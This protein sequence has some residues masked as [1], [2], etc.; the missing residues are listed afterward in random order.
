MNKNHII[1]I[2]AI[3]FIAIAGGLTY[4]LFFNEY[5]ETVNFDGTTLNVPH[6][7]FDKIDQYNDSNGAHVI[8]NRDKYIIKYFY[9]GD[10]NII[11]AVNFGKE[12][13]ELVGQTNNTGPNPVKTT[14]HG[15]T[16]Y[17]CFTSEIEHGN[18]LIISKNPETAKKIYDS[19]KSNPKNN[20]NNPSNNHTNYNIN[21]QS[22]N[23]QNNTKTQQVPSSANRGDSGSTP[24]PTPTPTPE[25]TPTPGPVNRTGKVLRI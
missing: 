17:V 25:P 16:V 9:W 3:I 14:Y 8:E 12:K 11:D 1:I 4:L 13:L 22:N 6:T 18:L 21:T 2:L 20:T 24:T 15:E 5:T 23:N 19:I 7:F 10:N